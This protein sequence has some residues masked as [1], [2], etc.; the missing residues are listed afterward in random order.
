MATGYYA[1]DRQEML[2]FL[3]DRCCQLLQVEGIHSH[4]WN[5]P[6]MRLLRLVFG[7]HMEDMRWQQFVVVAR[8]RGDTSPA[9]PVPAPA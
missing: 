3:P 7:R 6:R 8:R 5:G 4:W 1:H 2:A 9:T